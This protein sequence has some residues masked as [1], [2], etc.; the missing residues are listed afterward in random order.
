MLKPAFFSIILLL[1]AAD[2]SA[3]VWR[4]IDAKGN[5]HYVDTQTSIFTWVDE[6]GR[7]FYSDTP[8]HVGAVAVEL[9][10]HS[11]GALGELSEAANDDPDGLA[12]ESETPEQRAERELA[13]EHLC[14]H[15]TD[16]Y[17][18]YK[19]AERLYIT[20]ERGEKEY[21]SKRDVKATMKEAQASM[22]KFCD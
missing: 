4:W 8:D 7:V 14:E 12:F 15:A 6:N 1:T 18:S 13:E 3:D 20:N 19:T 9:V 16:A 2:A 5:T 10:W 21:L 11:S 22:K 17:E